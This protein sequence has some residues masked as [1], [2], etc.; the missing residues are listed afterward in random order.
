M[1]GPSRVVVDRA[2]RERLIAAG[3]GR[4]SSL[5]A[6]ARTR[7]GGRGGAYEITIGGEDF[8][9][10]AY[11]RGGLPRLIWKDRMFDDRR[12]QREVFALATARERGVATVEP[13]ASVATPAGLG[14]YRHYLLTLRL[15]GAI[16]L[17]SFLNDPHRSRAERWFAIRLAALAVKKA[18]DSGVEPIDLHPRNILIVETPQFDCRLVDLDGAILQ[19]GSLPPAVRIS[20]LARFVRFLE[21]HADEG[22]AAM[23]RADVARFIKIIEGESWKRI[24]RRVAAEV[25]R[26][27]RI[28]QF[29]ML[30]RPRSSTASLARPANSKFNKRGVAAPFKPE[31]S[32][33]FTAGLRARARTTLQRIFES[34]E[35]A[36]VREF[37]IIGVARDPRGQ[38]D[39]RALSLE[40]PCLRFLGG[41]FPAGGEAWRAG[42]RAA[43]GSRI[44]IINAGA[45]DARFLAEALDLTAHET[46]VVVGARGRDGAADRRT[47]WARMRDRI[48]SFILRFRGGAPV[49]DPLASFVAKRDDRF[50]AAMR[51]AHARRFVT[52]EILGLLSEAG[53]RIREA[54]VAAGVPSQ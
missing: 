34:A 3:I 4:P 25:A 48:L 52:A 26:T 33:I 30:W 50:E 21:R 1:V 19:G 46:D 18:F 32:F 22:G 39:L 28:H 20:A 45:L 49:A 9:L 54:P 35:T 47:A 29:G 42:I 17:L 15:P 23:S 43:R 11:R 38:N 51:A 10:R 40:T 16:E 37:E 8:I 24:H 12:S 31:I 5:I 7:E 13:V 27:R 41:I 14:F 2:R 6:A 44:I 36:G 53:A